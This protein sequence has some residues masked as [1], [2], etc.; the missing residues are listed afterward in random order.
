MWWSFAQR[1]HLG[2]AARQWGAIC[3]HPLHRLQEASGRHASS[4]TST[5]YRRPSNRTPPLQR[6]PKVAS[7]RTAATT[8][9]EPSLFA[10][11]RARTLA[12]PS[13]L[14]S[15]GICIPLFSAS[16]SSRSLIRPPSLAFPIYRVS[17]ML[18]IRIHDTSSVWDRP[19]D[20]IHDHVPGFIDTDPIGF[21]EKS[22]RETTDPAQQTNIRVAIE[23]LKSGGQI[24]GD[25]IGDGKLVKF[26]EWKPAMGPWLTN[27]IVSASVV[28]FNWHT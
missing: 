22:L 25:M 1:A 13:H 18:W 10:W 12:L 23:I 11:K 5:S 26:G 27:T 14:I 19:P 9:E 17:E 8:E 21:L 6:R 3:F 28:P 20:Y 24:P 16:S 2:A 15:A 4:K 7:P